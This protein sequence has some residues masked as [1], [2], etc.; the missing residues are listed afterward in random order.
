MY[1][2]YCADGSADD[3][4]Y[5]GNHDVGVAVVD[6]A[7][8]VVTTIRWVR[9]VLMILIVMMLIMVRMVSMTLMVRMVLSRRVAMPVLL[10]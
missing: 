1:G 3:D 8:Y 6:D 4:G 5:C 9:V 7:D 2:V 10:V